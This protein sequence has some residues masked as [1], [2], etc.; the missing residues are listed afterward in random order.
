MARSSCAVRVL[1]S[2]PIVRIEHCAHCGVLSLHFGPLSLRLDREA[3][4][5][6]L[7]T[8]QRALTTLHAAEVEAAA[9]PRLRGLAS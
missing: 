2:G 9:A 3:A 4:A 6:V 1:A 8:L 5:S 7:D